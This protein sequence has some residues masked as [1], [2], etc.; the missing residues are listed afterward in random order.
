MS[1]SLL[2]KQQNLLLIKTRSVQKRSMNNQR[3]KQ[4]S[5]NLKNWVQCLTEI[6]SERKKMTLSQQKKHLKLKPKRFPPQQ[7]VT[8][9]ERKRMKLTF[10]NWGKALLPSLKNQ[11]LLFPLLKKLKKSLRQ[12]QVHSLALENL[13]SHRLER[14]KTQRQR[15]VTKLLH[16]IRQK[17]LRLQK[18]A[19]SRTIRF[20][21]KNKSLRLQKQH[22]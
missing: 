20:H 4:R 13:T 5:Q 12:R 7:I 14:R 6:L 17:Y 10:K 19:R 15:M 9:L 3:K 8:L 22:R 16:R 11:T 2:M 1:Q 21:R 18:Q